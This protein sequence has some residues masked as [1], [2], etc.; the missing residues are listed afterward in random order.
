MQIDVENVV[1]V[2]FVVYNGCK[3]IKIVLVFTYK[4]MYFSQEE[5]FTIMADAVEQG[6]VLFQTPKE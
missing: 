6:M 3:Q 2:I 5:A 4:V 1:D